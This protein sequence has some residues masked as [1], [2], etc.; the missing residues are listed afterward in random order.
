RLGLDLVGAQRRERPR[1]RDAGRPVG[2][3]VRLRRP[4]CAAQDFGGPDVACESAL[5]VGDRAQIRI[6]EPARYR[7]LGAADNGTRFCVRETGTD[8]LRGANLLPTESWRCH[9]LILGRVA[10]PDA[11]IWRP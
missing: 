11:I 9:I 4:Q 7:S 6:L 10:A 2:L 8:Q 3:T 5:A 1:G